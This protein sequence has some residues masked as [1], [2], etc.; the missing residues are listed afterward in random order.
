MKNQIL[1]SVGVISYN[2]ANTIIET[3]DSIYNQ[4]YPFIELL[5]SDDCSD[6]STV[7]LCNEW[8]ETHSKRFKKVNVL[9]AEV[10]KGIPAN[11]NRILDNI[12]GEWIKMIAADDILLPSCIEDCMDFIAGNDSIY[13]MAG[14][15]KRYV[16]FF[17]EDCIIKEDTIYTESRLKVLNGSLQEQRIAI[18]N[19]SF[20]EAPALF[21]RTELFNKVGKYNEEYMFI[22]DWPMNKKMLDS[23][24]KCFFLNKHIVG[25][26]QSSANVCNNNSKL[27]NLNF[28]KSVY[29]FK[30]NELFVHHSS[31]Y[32]IKEILFFKFCVFMDSYKLNNNSTLSRYIWAFVNKVISFII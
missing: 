28:V 23:G 21:I 3:L 12:S 9:T 13:W 5:V 25:Y 22:E 14:R 32:R 24:F 4:S 19:Y 15:T 10:N 1:V 30:S 18:L 7:E 29:K 16:N 8:I 2:S 26:R 6:D 31:R 17:K 27:F 20:V 11:C